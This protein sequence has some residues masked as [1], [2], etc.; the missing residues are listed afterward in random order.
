MENHEGM[1]WSHSEFC[2]EHDRILSYFGRLSGVNKLLAILLR[3]VT[4]SVS[5]VRM[6]YFELRKNASA[7]IEHCA[8]SVS[9]LYACII[10]KSPVASVFSI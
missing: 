10:M 8:C 1:R 7:Y 3:F 5:Q 6:E 4:P 2:S 9:L